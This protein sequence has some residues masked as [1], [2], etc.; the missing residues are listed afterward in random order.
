MALTDEK[1]L[2]SNSLPES[3]EP[4]PKRCELSS[5]ADNADGYGVP[6]RTSSRPRKPKY[7]NDG[8]FDQ[9]GSF[10][11][12]SSDRKPETPSSPST[13]LS[14][15]KTS[16]LQKSYSIN[17]T[18]IADPLTSRCKSTSSTSLTSPASKVANG[19]N[20]KDF[21]SVINTVLVPSPLYINETFFSLGSK[22][23]TDDFLKQDGIIIIL[24]QC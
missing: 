3:S 17:L 8:D 21:Q 15:H 9:H 2:D 19:M 5:R 4:T 10:S 23:I 14:H 11:K 1:A 22:L 20:N 18:D 6:T 16:A 12:H 13:P 24:C 7:R